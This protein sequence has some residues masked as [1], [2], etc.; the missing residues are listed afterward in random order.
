MDRRGFVTTGMATGLAGFSGV[1]GALGA[2]LAE[3][4]P[5]S[6]ARPSDNGTVRLSSNENPLGLSES[7][8][9]AV[10]DAIVDANRYPGDF[11]PPLVEALSR[12]LGV[13]A[14]YLSL[15]AGSTEIL[16]MAV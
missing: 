13:D 5:W 1:G 7:A 6:S 15:G 8:R 12:Y 2:L 16:Q 3:T 14:S 11:R 10:V 4:S 9:K